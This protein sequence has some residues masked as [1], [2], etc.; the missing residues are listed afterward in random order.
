MDGARGALEHSLVEEEKL[1]LSEVTNLD[2]VHAEV[3]RQLKELRDR[4]NRIEN[5]L[6]YHLDVGQCWLYTCCDSYH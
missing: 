3:V 4:P 1:A 6:I 2:E 5:P